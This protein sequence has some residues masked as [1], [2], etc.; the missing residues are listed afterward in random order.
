MYEFRDAAVIRAT[1]QGTGPG[2]G[3]WPDLTGPMAGPE[4]WCSWLRQQL[5]V[6]GF[7]AALEQ[8][9]PVLAHRAREICEGRAVAEPA[10]RRAVLAV[11]RY[12]LRASGRA[13]PFGLFAGV[14]PARIAADPALRAGTAHRATARVEAR[15]LAAVIERLESDPVLAPRLMVQANNLVRERD[16]RLVLEHRSGGSTGA[17][18]TH[19]HVRAAPPA[20]MAL[21][22]ARAPILYTD[23]AGKLAAGFPGTAAPAIDRLLRE[24]V[25]QRL[26]LTSLRPGTTATDPLGHVLAA[27]RAAGADE[28]VGPGDR[29]ETVA[30]LR[31]ISDGLSRHDAAPTPD[32]ACKQREHVTALM[33]SRSALAEAPLTVDLRLD[34]DLTV[35]RQVADEAAR[36]AG[37]LVRLAPRGHLGPGWAAWHGRFLERYGPRA[38]VPLRDVVDADTGLGYPAGYLGAS[39]APAPAA[40]TDRDRR[41]LALAQKAALARRREVVLDDEMVSDLAVVD[42]AEPAQPTTELT[43]RIHAPA[44]DK[45]GF[46]LS[47]VGVSRSAGTTTGRFLDLFD[48]EDQERLT[49]AYAR[50]PTAY[51]GALQPQVSAAVPYTST[52][53]VARARQVMP[54]VLALGEF[55]TGAGTGR[56]SVDDIAV[57]SDAERVFLVSLSQRRTIEPVAFNAVEPVHYAHPLTRFVLEATKA[58]RTPCAVFDWGA[59]ASLPFLPALRYGRTVISPARWTL[60]DA[61]LPAPSAPWSQWDDALTAWRAETGL[62]DAV[63][64]GEGDQRLLLDLSEPA[65]RVLLRVH[66]DRKATAVLRGSVGGP[67]GWM[68]GHVHEVVIPL[69]TTDLPRP[70]PY[71]LDA[72]PVNGRQHG[73]LPGC[74]GRF[75]LKLYGHPDRRTPLLTAHLPRLLASL[76]DLADDAANESAGWWFLRYRDPQDHLRLRLNVPAGQVAAATKRIGAW[77]RQLRQAGLVARVEW[78]TYFPETTR[79]GGTDAMGAAEAYFCADSAA[80]LAQ[81]RACSAPGGPDPRAMTA[82]SMLDTVAAVLGNPDEGMRWLIAHA[83]TTPS[84]PARALYDQTVALANPHDQHA[85]AG[86]PAGEAVVSAWAQRRRTLTAYRDVLAASPR[87]GAAGLLP[88][89]LHLHHVRMSGVSAED[90]RACLHL[91]RAA[92][93]S[94]SARTKKGT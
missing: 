4:S 61:E 69:A 13:T 93:L 21:A 79:F 16:G 65:H 14:A 63:A 28:P 24:L 37:V 68:R 26:L 41:L 59:A 33:R 71:W 49:A 62:P 40:V 5:T 35:P 22:A 67:V 25:A 70:A 90:E 80:V 77:T 53:N 46:V 34:W 51:E 38:M 81:L 76:D 10:V 84:A 11:L 85:L 23:L 89:L 58:L 55:D 64:L 39:P 83:R 32:A 78:D 82:A 17:P 9:S 1:A 74:D 87:P 18:P 50:M 3:P 36:A 75:S 56:I 94:W 20:A 29:A 8:A 92:A 12:A 88:E 52:E 31:E 27:V 54:H 60:H 30:W 86:R 45:D 57:T 73:H 2:T 72:V 48:E 47:V 15:W 91:A 44:D 42:P 66:L 7:A 6:P 43:V 19:M